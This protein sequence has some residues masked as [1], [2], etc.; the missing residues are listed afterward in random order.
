MDAAGEPVGACRLAWCGRAKANEKQSKAKLGTAKKT[1][2][3]VPNVFRYLFHWQPAASS[4]E[5]QRKG[6]QAKA[7][8]KQSKAK[9]SKRVSTSQ[10]CSVTCFTASQQPS[11]KNSKAKQRQSKANKGTANS[12]TRIKR[13]PLLVS[14]PASSQKQRRRWQNVSNAPQKQS[15]AKQRRANKSKAK[16]TRIHVPNVFRYVLHCQPAT[17][18]KEPNS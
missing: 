12:H 5:K 6:E 13:M 3:S 11:A 10:T 9:H 16:Q 7:K 8:A 15:N 18:S 14:L 17:S 2:S 1:R 4:K